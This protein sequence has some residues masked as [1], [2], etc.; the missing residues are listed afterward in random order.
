MKHLLLTALLI[1][2]LFALGQKRTDTLIYPNEK[3]IVET[4]SNTLYTPAVRRYVFNAFLSNWF[5]GAGMGAQVFFGNQESLKSL[6]DR[7]TPT[8]EGYVG[9]WIH[10]AVGLRLKFGGGPVKSYT[11]G[12]LPVQGAHSLV[13]GTPDGNGIYTMRWHHLYGEGD[14]MVDL[15]NAIGGYNPARFYSAIPYLGVG[16]SIVQNQ[17]AHNGDRTAMGI[18]GLLNRFRITNQ[19]DINVEIK[20]AIVKQTFDREVTTR[21]FESLVMLTA[22]IAYRFGKPH[23][24][25]FVLD[26]GASKTVVA[27]TY[28]PLLTIPNKSDVVDTTARQ[29]VIHEVIVEKRHVLTHP[30]AVFFDLNMATITDRSKVNLAFVADIIKSSGGAR[31]RLTGSADSRTA[32][33]AYNQRLSVKRST[34]VRDY[35]VKTLLVDP[36]QL[37]LDPVGGIDRFS[38]YEVNRIVII[39]Q[40]PQTEQ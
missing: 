28:R 6:G 31:F 39:S 36:D 32:S 2:S 37:I 20:D 30:M 13:V 12:T 8:Y 26:Q 5:I 33:P 38:P 14:I 29:E 24:S 21:D 7:I 40:E 9:K 18:F 16:V 4:D 35:L 19:F 25:R 15:N 22:G 34:A 23:E 27:K 10:P 17:P 3:V 11:T 1:P